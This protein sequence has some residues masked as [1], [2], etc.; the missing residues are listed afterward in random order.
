VIEAR[1]AGDDRLLARLKALPD[2]AR[3]GIGRAMLQLAQQ[4]QDKIRSDKLSGQVLEAHSGTLRAGIAYDF[5]DDGTA[6]TVTVGSAL[7]YARFQEFGTSASYEI[8]PRTARVLA[9]PWKGEARFF[10]KIMHPP[11][12]ERSFLR[13]ALAELGPGIEAGLREAIDRDLPR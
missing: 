9:F 5:T 2:A 1:L 10:K 4:L 8:L 12:P 3:A 7:R 11:L 6:F 13:S